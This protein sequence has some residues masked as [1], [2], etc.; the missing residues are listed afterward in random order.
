[1]EPHIT[2]ISPDRARI[3]QELRRLGESRELLTLLL[4]RD[5]QSRYANT[6]GGWA[7][8]L[9]KPA[10]QLAVYSFVF[11]YILQQHAEGTPYVLFL[12]AGLIPWFVFSE[13]VNTSGKALEMEGDLI[14]K[15]RITRLLLPFWKSIPPLIDLGI[16]LFLFGLLALVLGQPPTWKI[17]FLPFALAFNW[18]LGF[19][20]S[21]WLNYWFAMRRDYYHLANNILGFGLWI[22]PIF[23]GI[24]QIPPPFDWAM[25]ANPFGAMVQVYRFALCAEHFPPAYLLGLGVAALLALGGLWSFVKNQHLFAENI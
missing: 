3:P 23:Y 24:R 1:M 21:L 2:E 11:G 12:F 15:M 17:L 14:K 16:Y 18:G 10:I 9:F 19:A 5:F 4:R 25:A 6:W 8:A 7:W 22:S 13:I 20:V